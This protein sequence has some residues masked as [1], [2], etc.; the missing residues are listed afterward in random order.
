MFDN[1]TVSLRLETLGGRIRV[2]HYL[3]FNNSQQ[4]L[5]LR[6]VADLEQLFNEAETASIEKG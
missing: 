2:P 3:N 4:Q 1:A 6:L 5:T